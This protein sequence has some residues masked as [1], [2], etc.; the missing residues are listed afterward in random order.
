MRS[1][2]LSKFAVTRA[3]I[4]EAFVIVF[5]A[6]ILGF[7]IGFVVAMS[8]ISQQ[9]LFT[10]LPLPFAVGICRQGKNDAKDECSDDNRFIEPCYLTFCLLL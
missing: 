5:S 2:G 7:I 10:Q 3:Y 6:S 1:I 4:G 9:V 8:M